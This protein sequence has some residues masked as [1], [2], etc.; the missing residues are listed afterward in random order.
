[1]TGNLF[2]MLRTFRIGSWGTLSKAFFFFFK[3]VQVVLRC[4][5]SDRQLSTI[6]LFMRSYLCSY[7]ILFCIFCILN[8]RCPYILW[9][10]IYPLLESILWFV[11]Y[12]K[13]CILFFY[14][15]FLHLFC[16]FF[17]VVGVLLLQWANLEVFLVLKW[18]LKLIYVWM[19]GDAA[20]N[21]F[22]SFPGDLYSYLRLSVLIFF[23]I[24]LSSYI[25]CSIFL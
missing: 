11:C 24:G 13:A 2:K 10:W 18:S 16:P 6:I 25:C 21:F 1:M 9:I 3:S 15:R 22:F 17:M 8:G 20:K 4:F 14:G 23:S 7:M 5:C 19:I 12:G